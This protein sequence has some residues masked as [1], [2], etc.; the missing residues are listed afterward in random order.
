MLPNISR[1][2]QIIKK[3]YKQLRFLFIELNY[4]FFF[5]NAELQYDLIY[6]RC[7]QLVCSARIKQSHIYYYFPCVCDNT[8]LLYTSSLI[9][10]FTNTQ[11]WL[12]AVWLIS[13]PFFVKVYSCYK[14]LTTN[15][16]KCS[17]TCGKRRLQRTP[18]KPT[19]STYGRK[20][21]LKTIKL[22]DNIR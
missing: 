7:K 14:L 12:V 10:N 18:L 6:A 1:K 22:L 4:N 16:Q 9:V 13:F 21:H 15:G 2:C 17:A 11:I 3:I 8:F 20:N 5:L 19:L